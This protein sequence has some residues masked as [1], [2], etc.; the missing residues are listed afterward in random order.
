MRPMIRGIPVAV[1]GAVLL[2]GGASRVGAQLTRSGG[3]VSDSVPRS[4]LVAVLQSGSGDLAGTDNPVVTVGALPAEVASEFYVPR[5]ATVIGAVSGNSATIGFLH[6]Y[7]S[8][9]SLRAEFTRELT[10][11]GWRTPPSPALSGG[12]FR[13]TAMPRGAP[14]G[15]FVLCRGPEMLTISTQPP[16]YAAANV[17][18]RL[19]PTNRGYACHPEQDGFPFAD[20]RPYRPPVMPV[21]IN[22]PGFGAYAP[23]NRCVSFNATNAASTAATATPL[24]AQELLGH[25]ERQLS[26]SGWVPIPRSSVV[27]HTWTRTDSTGAHEEATIYVLTLGDSVP[28]LEPH[29]ELRVRR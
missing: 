10:A 29:L 9:D 25:Y 8:T 12:G 5:G 21:L 20:G 16:S 18:L 3:P 17:V 1:A 7:G 14:V 4:L 22:P 6:I 23:N 11:R 28:C 13:T 27:G 24:A 19:E 2:A 15:S 26:D